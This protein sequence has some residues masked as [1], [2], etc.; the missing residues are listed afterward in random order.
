MG[1]L[2]DDNRTDIE[3]Q[4]LKGIHDAEQFLIIGNTR[5]TAKF[6]MLDVICVDA[7][8]DLDLILQFGEKSDFVVRFISRQYTCCVIVFKHLPAKF[9]IELSVKHLD[10]LKDL[11]SLHLQVLLGVKC[12]ICHNPPLSV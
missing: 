7:D 4:R 3:I 5:I 9:Q 12:D 10:P 6:G 1:I 8:N 2:C 11:V